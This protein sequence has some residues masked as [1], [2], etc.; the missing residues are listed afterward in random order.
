[1][2]CVVRVPPVYLATLVSVGSIKLVTLVYLYHVNRWGTHKQLSIAK[3][4]FVQVCWLSLNFYNNTLRKF[5]KF[6]DSRQTWTSPTLQSVDCPISRQYH[7]PQMRKRVS[8]PKVQVYPESLGQCI[9]YTFYKFLPPPPTIITTNWNW[10]EIKLNKVNIF[11]WW[12]QRIRNFKRRREKAI[13]PGSQNLACLAR[14]YTWYSQA[15]K[16]NGMIEH[17]LSDRACVAW[18]KYHIGYLATLVPVGSMHRAW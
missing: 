18:F 6:S 1:M 12:V 10:L 16:L 14:L 3:L 15:C 4:D 2:C 17:S 5:Y 8:Y 13:I 11:N 7:R 9:K